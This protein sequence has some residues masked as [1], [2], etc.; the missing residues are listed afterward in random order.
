MK[1]SDYIIDF[2]V[3]QNVK[4][5]FL[6]TGGAVAHIVDS[7]GKRKEAKGDIDYIA[8]QHE[9]AGAMAA[10]VY[11]RLGPGIGVMIATSGPGAT[12]LITG[13]CGCWFDSV[14]GLF[15]TGQVSEKESQDA[16]LTKPRQVGFQETDIVSIVRPITKYA[17]KV[18]D[19]SKIREELEKA[20]HIAKEGRPGPVLVDLPV[21]IQVE[22]IDPA[23][24]RGFSPNS[25]ESTTPE[26]SDEL[27]E[28][29]VREAV[30]LL[31]NAKRPIVLFGGGVRLANGQSEALALIEQ[32]GIPAVVSWSGFDLLSH[33]HPL[34]VGHI[35]VYGNRAANLAIQNADVV[36]SFG[37]RLD[38]RQTGGR[39]D[40]FARG[41]KKIMVDIDSAEI[42]KGRGLAIDVGIVADVRRV[43]PLFKNSL[44]ESL[45]ISSWKDHVQAW[46]AVYGG[47]VEHGDQEGLMNAYDFLALLSQQAS[48]K[49]VVIADEGG[50]LVW[51]MQ[52]WK[53]KQGQRMISTFGNSPMGYALP[54]SIGAAAALPKENIICIDG[55]GG[56]QMNIQELQTLVSYKLPV[57]I[58][59]MN[60]QC[61][62]IIK[63][64]QDLYFDSKY[65]ATSE[66]YG[67]QSPDFV[68]VAEAYGI[69][70]F[71]ID[72]LAQAKDGIA[73]A[74]SMEGPVLVDVR[75]DTE[76]KLNPKLEFGRP[77][78]DMAPYLDRK[79]LK[80]IMIEPLLPESEKIPERTGWI[81]LK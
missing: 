19:P 54:A 27:L 52:S 80:N 5:A 75:I 6:I 34:F 79:E 78:E 72:S 55:D 77:L 14:P 66:E 22:E 44:L 65:Y 17:V 73:R 59:I 28:R 20:V 63:Q 53:I 23:T 29:K 8:V 30:S 61:M 49:Q 58:F 31:R 62:G 67:Y 48:E 35:G 71:S 26:D 74:L 33:D 56:F 36:L 81:N 68:K 10:E 76:Q 40:T 32:W 11:S 60:N 1:I 57:K 50:N 51:T 64:F 13:M 69:S 45:E 7:I 15:I 3:T 2:L 43:L 21:N 24:L 38:T 42:G 39:V 25:F 12:N 9:Q 70:A 16:T 18:T 37:S 41:A 46:R 4:T 47:S